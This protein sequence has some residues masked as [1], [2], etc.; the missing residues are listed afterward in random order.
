MST[1]ATLALS[2]N[3][4]LY[5]ELDKD[6]GDQADVWLEFPPEYLRL[7][8]GT[9]HGIQVLRIPVEDWNAIRRGTFT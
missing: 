7:R 9:R 4:H 2:G 3:W 1:R 5:R 8:V 6:E